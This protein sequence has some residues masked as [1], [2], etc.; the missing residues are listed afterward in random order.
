VAQ[1][2]HAAEVKAL[3]DEWRLKVTHSQH[4]SGA[5]I[6]AALR[7]TCTVVLK[8]IQD[9]MVTS[10]PTIEPVIQTPPPGFP[11]LPPG[12]PP[13]QALQAPVTSVA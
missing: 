1:A 2:K 4:Q 13:H 10:Y 6:R 9:R 3:N 5:I 12:F 8:T 7:E 11:P